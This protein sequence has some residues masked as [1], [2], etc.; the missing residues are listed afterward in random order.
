M[1][2]CSVFSET[3]ALQN[4]SFSVNVHITCAFGLSKSE[5]KTA[6]WIKSKHETAT[7]IKSKCRNTHVANQNMKQTRGRKSKHETAT[8]ANHKKSGAPHQG[9]HQLFSI[10]H[11][12][13]HAHI[14]CLRMQCHTSQEQGTCRRG[15]SA[16]LISIFS[17]FISGRTEVVISP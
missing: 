2:I 13:T 17:D 4:E 11:T 3:K 1:H 5:H 16:L 10:Q 8:G 6:T 15:Q 14:T 12:H 7:W 9:T